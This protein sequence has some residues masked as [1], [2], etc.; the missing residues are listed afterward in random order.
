MSTC[1]RPLAK[2]HVAASKWITKFTSNNRQ[3]YYFMQYS[4]LFHDTCMHSYISNDGDGQI[5]ATAT[6]Y[7]SQHVATLT[8]LHVYMHTSDKYHNRVCVYLL[9]TH[10]LTQC[11]L[12]CCCLCL[13]ICIYKY[14]IAVI[15]VDAVSVNATNNAALLLER[16]AITL[17][18]WWS[19]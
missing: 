1:T 5:N 2:Q 19:I 13:Y 7:C 15:S 12:W 10:A 11:R 17:E 9:Q 8:T 14:N 18:C 3:I 4:A 16:R 6:K